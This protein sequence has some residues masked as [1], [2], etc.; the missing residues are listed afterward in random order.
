MERPFQ[1]IDMRAD[2][3]F[4]LQKITH[5][6]LN[7]SKMHII[8][9]TAIKVTQTSLANNFMLIKKTYSNTKE[10]MEMPVAKKRVKLSS[11]ISTNLPTVK[12]IGVIKQDKLDDLEKMIEF[13]DPKCR[14]FHQELCRQHRSSNKKI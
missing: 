14:A 4:D 7:T 11:D 1:A 10:W 5:G 2:D 6:L 3:I 9:V 13:L 8:T 12:N